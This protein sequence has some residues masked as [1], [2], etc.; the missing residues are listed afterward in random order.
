M[1]ISLASSSQIYKATCKGY[2]E[3]LFDDVKKIILEHCQ[4]LQQ[5]LNETVIEHHSNKKYFQQY[6]A[7]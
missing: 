7:G 1:K 4:G 2:V 3:R 5:Q 6:L